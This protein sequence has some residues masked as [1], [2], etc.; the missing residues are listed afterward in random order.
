L[1]VSAAAVML[2]A[3]C[4][5]DDGGSDDDAGNGGGG[6]QEYVEAAS[7]SLR[8]DGEFPLGPERTDCA[9]AALVDV[10]DVDTLTDAGISPEEFGDADNL[11]SL[12]VDLPDDVADRLG[13]A[14]AECDLVGSIEDVAV[15]T[16]TSSA[17]RELSSDA[18]ACLRDNLDDQTVVDALAR[19][20]VDGSGEHV[21]APLLSAVAACP[22][23]LTDVALAQASSDLSPAG[24]ACLTDF[25]EGNADLV[26]QALTSGSRE[27]RQEARA[28]LAAA[29][30][31]VAAVLGG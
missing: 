29:C 17:G 11:E 28:R 8:E 31:D 16:F 7:A 15:D 27:A 20:F 26:A 5:D 23:V 2:L 13:N 3:A 25:V 19:T 24:E 30:P 1:A 12:D 6:S 10:V 18:A 21:Q 4:G 14:L 22:P 9:A